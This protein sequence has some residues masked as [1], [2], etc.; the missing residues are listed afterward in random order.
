MMGSNMTTFCRLRVGMAINRTTLCRSCGNH[1]RGRGAAVSG[2]LA[3]P[4][5]PPRS[6][7][8]SLWFGSCF[9]PGDDFV[10]RLV[11]PT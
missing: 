2:K 4:G 6:E 7:W 11:V 1:P 10:R 9:V 5:K 3:A 8:L